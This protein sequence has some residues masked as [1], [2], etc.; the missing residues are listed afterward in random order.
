MFLMSTQQ[1][2]QTAPRRGLTGSARTFDGVALN[3][4][5]PMSNTSHSGID[6]EHE[7]CE[8]CDTPYAPSTDGLFGY[9][10]RVKHDP[11]DTTSRFEFYICPC[12]ALKLVEAIADAVPDGY[13]DVL[14]EVMD[15][16]VA[17]RHRREVMAEGGR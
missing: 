4:K 14:A 13:F 9:S 15:R 17:R 3:S 12:C 8:L 5:R 7:L 6:N 16:V 1:R 11:G 10:I 2:S